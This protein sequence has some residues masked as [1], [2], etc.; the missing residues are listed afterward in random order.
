[1]SEAENDRDGAT[2]GWMAGG[3]LQGFVAVVK[4]G[5]YSD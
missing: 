4:T 5:F 2:G 3:V 1:M